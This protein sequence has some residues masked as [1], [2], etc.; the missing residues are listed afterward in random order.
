MKVIVT[1]TGTRGERQISGVFPLTM[2]TRSAFSA[3]KKGVESLHQLDIK[4]TTIKMQE[5]PQ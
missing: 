3:L 5:W 2:P 4:P 1:Y